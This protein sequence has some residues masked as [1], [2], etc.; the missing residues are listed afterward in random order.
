M[1]NSL[2]LV[3]SLA[4][5]S[6]ALIMAMGLFNG[7]VMASENTS[8]RVIYYS[9]QDVDQASLMQTLTRQLTL[10]DRIEYLRKMRSS[11]HVLRLISTDEKS[12]RN[13]MQ[14][15]KQLPLT[16]LLENDSIIKIQ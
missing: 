13:M 12:L 11:G 1:K 10:P 5:W 8:L 16:R 7:Q 3:P 14:T 4:C 2:L 6:I 15:I 9:H